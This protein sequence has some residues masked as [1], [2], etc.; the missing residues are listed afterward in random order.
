MIQVLAR[1][2]GK[3]GKRMVR[4]P[5]PANKT[6]FE[7]GH[8]FSRNEVIS[9][10]MGAVTVGVERKFRILTT[11]ITISSRSALRLFGTKLGWTMIALSSA[12]CLLE[13]LEVSMLSY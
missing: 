6:R 10:M 13:V 2:R 11:L 12:A 4:A 7:Q 9:G 5:Y 8:T 3:G 1:A